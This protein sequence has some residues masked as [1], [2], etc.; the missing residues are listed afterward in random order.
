MSIIAYGATQIF[1]PEAGFIPRINYVGPEKAVVIWVIVSLPLTLLFILPRQDSRL[2]RRVR[3]GGYRLWTIVDETPTSY[4]SY[5][6]RGFRRAVQRKYLQQFTRSFPLIL[7]LLFFPPGLFA[8]IRNPISNPTPIAVSYIAIGVLLGTTGNGVARVLVESNAA[9]MVEN[10]AQK[11]LSSQLESGFLILAGLI[12]IA[13]SQ[14]LSSNQTAAS[15]I[16][17]LILLIMIYLSH[18]G[19]KSVSGIDFSNE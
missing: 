14:N 4:D 9:G 17:G 16:Y 13:A 6:E 19:A 12:Q 8:F 1:G 10:E 2:R 3:E 15:L 5:S 11:I 18:R 7:F